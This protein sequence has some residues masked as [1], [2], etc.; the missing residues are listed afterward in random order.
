MQS[1]DKQLVESLTAKDTTRR[2]SHG[3]DVGHHESSMYMDLCIQMGRCLRGAGISRW[4]S[5]RMI[6][7]G[8]TMMVE[9]YLEGSG[10]RLISEIGPTSFDYADYDEDLGEEK[11]AI[12][13]GVSWAPRRGSKQWDVAQILGMSGEDVIEVKQ[14]LAQKSITVEVMLVDI[15]LKIGPCYTT[16][17]VNTLIIT[18]VTWITLRIQWSASTC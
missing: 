11:W 7:E 4:N 9:V 18:I 15:G 13:C 3:G 16:Q 17:V 1:E 14:G 2:M 10:K 12:D 8:Y 5:G 6:S